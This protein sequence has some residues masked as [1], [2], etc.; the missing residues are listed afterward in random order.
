VVYEDNARLYSDEEVQAVAAAVSARLTLQ[1]QRLLAD[2]LRLRQVRMCV[3][4]CVCVCVCV[5]VCRVCV[6]VVRWGHVLRSGAVFARGVDV[7]TH[8]ATCR[9][10]LRRWQAL[11]HAHTPPTHQPHTNNTPTTHR[12]HADTTPPTRRPHTTHTPPTAGEQGC[13]QV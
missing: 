9:H 8:G 4:A 6:C 2:L 12:A 13:C 10:A 5:C 3:C 1:Q 11:P 7:T